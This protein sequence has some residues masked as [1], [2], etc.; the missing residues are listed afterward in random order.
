MVVD[1]ILTFIGVSNPNGRW[2]LFWGGFGSSLGEL[3]ILGVVWRKVNCHAKGVLPRR[4]A[5][6]GGHAVRHLQE[7]PP[8]T[9]RQPRDH[10]G[11]DR[12][13]PRRG[14]R[15][16]GRLAATLSLAATCIGRIVT[17]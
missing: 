8:D 9:S 10:R 6:R 12:A 3:A 17:T 5:S 16:S 7:A 11:A 13:G 15:P 14:A 1:W 2:Y 4:V